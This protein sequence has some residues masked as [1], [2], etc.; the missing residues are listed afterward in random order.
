MSKKQIVVSEKAPKAIGPYSVA[1]RFGDL[2]F[3]S[4][5]LGLDPTNGNLVAGGV[6]AETRQALENLKAVLEAAGTSFANVMK[7]TIFL[8]D[9]ADFSR[10]NTIYGEY[11]PANSPARST[12]QV[13]AL[14]KGGAVEI[15]AVACLES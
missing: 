6:E 14:P 12:V 8:R 15:E 7:T 13:A 3:A 9:M 2:V 5:Q 4:G 1:T 10:V 11:F